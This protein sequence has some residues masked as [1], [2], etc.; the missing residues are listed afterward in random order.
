MYVSLCYVKPYFG[1]LLVPM[2]EG[3]RHLIFNLNPL[4]NGDKCSVCINVVIN[5][6]FACV[7]KLTRS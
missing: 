1:F 4:E 7:S 3:V 6:F 5:I 2:D